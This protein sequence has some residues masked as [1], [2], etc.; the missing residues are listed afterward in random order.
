MGEPAI[1]AKKSYAER[2]VEIAV[3]LKG[4][5]WG[6]GDRVQVAGSTNLT[7]EQARALAAQIVAVAD[8]AD[9]RADKRAAAEDRRRKWRNRQIASGK[10]QVWGAP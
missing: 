8:E 10:I 9:A 3:K 2:S 7:T 1:A 5:G 6:H 4:Q